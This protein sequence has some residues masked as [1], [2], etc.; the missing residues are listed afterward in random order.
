MP[1]E[2]GP[3]PQAASSSAKPASQDEAALRAKLAEVQALLTARAKEEAER[4]ARRRGRTPEERQSRAA[5]MHGVMRM[6][7]GLPEDASATSSV[8]LPP[9]QLRRAPPNLSTRQGRRRAE[10]EARKRGEA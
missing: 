8:P 6:V 7:T 1:G 9:A 5:F 2:D 10:R 3:E 4:A